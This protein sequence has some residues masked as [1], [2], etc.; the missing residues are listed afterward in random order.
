MLTGYVAAAAV[1]A[2][3]TAAMGACTLPMV[4]RF[5][6]RHGL[7]AANYEGRVIPVGLG[8]F[9][10]LVHFEYAVAMECYGAFGRLPGWPEAA[11]Y[12]YWLAATFVFFAGWLDD[13]VGDPTVKGWKGH[14]RA[15]RSVGTVTTGL[16][17]AMAT[18]SAALW[19]VVDTASDVWTGALQW[20]VL[21]LMTNALNL[22][23]LRPGRAL[24]CFTAGAAALML[25]GK[26]AALLYGLNFLFPSVVASV[27]L[28][29]GDLKA[30]HMLGDAGANLLGFAL[31]YAAIIVLPAPGL[32]ALA[33]L[34][35]M[36]N[37]AAEKRSITEWIE[38]HKWIRWL[39]RLGRME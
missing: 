20:L 25:C 29:P 18:G 24:K 32:A 17:K 4:E 7:R 38:R 2:I 13:T 5:L 34:L 8:L 37:R 10:W 33:L 15:L 22:L 21:T 14:W 28:L 1:P 26:F 12:K 27:L 36:L 30:R 39:D 9:V 23:D 3:A 19:L 6:N 16:L 11:F 35:A 31:G